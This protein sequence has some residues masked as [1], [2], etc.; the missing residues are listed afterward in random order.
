MNRV[1]KKSHMTGLGIV[2][3]S[4]ILSLAPIDRA[5]AAGPM[6]LK[7]SHSWAQ[8]DL[9]HKWAVWFSQAVEQQTKGDIKFEIY[10]GAVLFKA[11]A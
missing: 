7:I 1:M 9:R 5:C 8:D 2:L 11:V 6:V 10:P 3:F 4:L